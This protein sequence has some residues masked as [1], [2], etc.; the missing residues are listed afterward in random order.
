M[1]FNS[2]FK[3]LI[4]S[5]YCNFWRHHIIYTIF[6][7]STTIL[8]GILCIRT[9]NFEGLTCKNY[10]LRNNADNITIHSL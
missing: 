7:F 2:A 5:T 8:L 10:T 6:F 3:V 1:G 4:H 9:G